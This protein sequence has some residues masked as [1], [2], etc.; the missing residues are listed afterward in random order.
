MNANAY[1]FPNSLGLGAY[2]F[3]V[4]GIDASGLSGNWA[5]TLTFRS[6]EPVT[7]VSPDG[8]MFNPFPTLTWLPVPG[9]TNYELILR[10]T[11]TG[12]A[13]AWEQSL[14]STSWT[15]RTA[16]AG[17]DYRWSV[18]GRLGNVLNGNW[19]LTKDF[20]N[21]GRPVVL[22]TS[23]TTTDRTPTIV[24]SAV[25]GADSYHVNIVRLDTGR[26]I[27]YVQNLKGTSFAPLTD[28][29][30]REY[31]IWVRAVSTTG[32]ISEWGNFVNITITSADPPAIN[33]FIAGDSVVPVLMP[34][35]FE[36]QGASDI[37][38]TSITAGSSITM[39]SETEIEPEQGEEIALPMEAGKVPQQVSGNIDIVMT[40]WALGF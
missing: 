2:S 16:L 13:A 38:D 29:A 6:I 12:A 7:L 27:L 15:P 25:T 14:T 31:R 24:W 1:Q 19:S 28:L 36:D 17:G 8:S 3:S 5:S 39:A 30:P 10:N 23:G 20:N 18:R 21:R 11:R 40:E 22:T 34:D 33:H 35:V 9:A 32:V 37:A 4:S 26:A